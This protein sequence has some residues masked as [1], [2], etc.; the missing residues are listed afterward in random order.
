M[1]EPP[2]QIVNDPQQCQWPGCDRLAEKKKAGRGSPPKYCGKDG[3]TSTAASKARHKKRLAAAN[4]AYTESQTASEQL[5]R[6]LPAEGRIRQQILALATAMQ[7]SQKAAAVE[8]ELLDDVL[9]DLDNWKDEEQVQE[10]LNKAFAERDAAQDAAARATDEN[11]TLQATVVEV[12]AEAEDAVNAKEA[13]R[14]EA[15]ANRKLAHEKSELAESLQLENTA[16]QAKA[17]ES[18]RKKKEADYRAS[19]AE[20]SAGQEAAARVKAET[21]LEI[22]E[23]ERKK[24]EQARDKALE[25]IGE[26]KAE[27][28]AKK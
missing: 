16:L 27:L 25:T 10:R 6:S 13:M 1:A 12:T 18:D 11:T 4:D 8:V 24:A 7:K 23:A 15:E 26:L 28:K 3:H 5:A 21:A 19:E 22:Q 20:K 14:Q 2:L 9:N 17:E